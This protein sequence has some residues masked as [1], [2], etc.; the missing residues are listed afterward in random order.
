MQFREFLEYVIVAG[1]L[2]YARYSYDDLEQ[3]ASIKRNLYEF[4]DGMISVDYDTL[5]DFMYI[6]IRFV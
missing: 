1:R 2:Y 4:S 5:G 6:Q 3:L